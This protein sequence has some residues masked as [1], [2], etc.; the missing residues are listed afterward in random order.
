MDISRNCKAK[1]A[2]AAG[3][4][5]RD[6]LSELPDYLLHVILSQLKARQVV[7]TCILSRQW[8]HLWLT[9]PCLDVDTSEFPLVE[10][11]ASIPPH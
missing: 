7:Q 3:A 6:R 10:K 4:R 11:R 1:L 9:S 2:D 5:G 8:R